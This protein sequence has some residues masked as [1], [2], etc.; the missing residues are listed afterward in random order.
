MTNE[1]EEYR[2]LEREAQQMKAQVAAD[3]MRRPR[4]RWILRPL[5][6]LFGWVAKQIDAQLK[7]GGWR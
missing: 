3:M 7:E 4:H 1:P 5:H 2:K 6:R